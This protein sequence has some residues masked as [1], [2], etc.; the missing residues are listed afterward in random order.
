[1][2]LRYSQQDEYM[3]RLGDSSFSLLFPTLQFVPWLL[4]AVLLLRPTKK[5]STNT[6]DGGDHLLHCEVAADGDGVG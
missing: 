2:A 3:T 1:M 5:E 4:V 6:T